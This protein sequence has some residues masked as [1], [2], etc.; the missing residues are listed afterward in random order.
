MLCWGNECN[1]DTAYCS[2]SGQ[3]TGRG[4]RGRDR[5]GNSVTTFNWPFQ[6]EKQMTEHSQNREEYQQNR[7]TLVLL[8]LMEQGVCTAEEQP[9][10]SRSE[11]CKAVTA[12]GLEKGHK[13]EIFYRQAPQDLTMS[14]RTVNSVQVFAGI[15]RLDKMPL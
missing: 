3:K 9:R 1:R 5:D 10:N 11:Q 14:E 15:T 4:W 6:V 12:R 2:S 13:S 7:R 8:L